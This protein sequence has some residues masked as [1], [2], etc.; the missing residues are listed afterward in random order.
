MEQ[1][2]AQVLSRHNID[3]SSLLEMELETDM[4]M[5]GAGHAS[6]DISDM[7]VSQEGYWIEGNRVK[8]M[9]IWKG[10]KGMC[11]L[12]MPEQPELLAQASF[13]LFASFA[14]RWTSADDDDSDDDSSDSDAGVTGTDVPSGARSPRPPGDPVGESSAGHGPPST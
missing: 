12:I 11:R 5:G 13:A 10:L 3:S 4:D 9:R 6:G 8:L 7:L 1:A 14:Y 2:L